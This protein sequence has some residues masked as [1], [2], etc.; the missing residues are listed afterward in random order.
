MGEDR[1]SE[2]PDGGMNRR[3]AL[4]VAAGLGA[5]A[6]GAAVIGGIVSG[7]RSGGG[8]ASASGAPAVTGR[9]ARRL[10]MVTTWPKNFPGLGTGAARLGKRITE[11]SGG[12]LDV[13]VYAG[14]ELVPALSAF[15][16][17]SSGNADMY[18]A[19]IITGRAAPRPSTSSPPCR[20]A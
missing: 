15:D 9:A 13:T 8:V 7:H 19:R 4:Q 17:V 14:G 16:A 2:K 1:K 12:E 3:R 20:W 5:A 10:R 11:L 6:S 18:T